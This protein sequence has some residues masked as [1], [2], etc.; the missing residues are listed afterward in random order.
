MLSFMKAPLFVRDLT[1]EER[2]QLEISLRSKQAFTL[3][4]A[5][6]LLA[7]ANQQTATQIAAQLACGRQTVREAIHAFHERGLACLQE[8]SHVPTSVQPVLGADK[9]QRLQEILHQSPRLFQK[10]RTTWTLD[11][12]AEVAQEEGLSETV[13][14]AP[15]ML[16]AVR[17]LGASWK[18]AKHWIT[19]PDPAYTRKKTDAIE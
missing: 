1:P 17:R 4:R 3:K 8:G 11:L 12:L 7:S 5:Q 13:L 16:D 14:S 9:R 6:I 19:S 2:T 18:R 15:T 10:E